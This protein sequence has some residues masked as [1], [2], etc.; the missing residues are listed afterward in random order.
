MTSSG[1]FKA[2]ASL[3]AL[4]KATQVSESKMAQSSQVFYALYMLSIYA[5]YVYA[6]IHTRCMLKP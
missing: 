1:Y 5:L 4:R 6:S 3:S 2:F